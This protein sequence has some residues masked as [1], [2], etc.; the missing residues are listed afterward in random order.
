MKRRM[1]CSVLF[2]ITLLTAAPARAQLNGSHTLGDFGVQSGTQPAPGL[3]AASSH[4]VNRSSLPIP[5]VQHPG[6]ITFDAKDPDT[7]FPPIRDLRP[8]KGAPNWE[9]RLRVA[10]A[11]Q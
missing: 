8:P 4:D 10:M 1:L 11:R 5:D 7:K 3:Y 6:L 2:A 9:E